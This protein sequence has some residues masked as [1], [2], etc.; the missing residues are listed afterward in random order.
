M[1]TPKADQIN[2]DGIPPELI[3]LRQWVCWRYERRGGK[4]T[5]V[6]YRP[7][8]RK[9]ADSTNP[10]T[11]GDYSDA[12]AGLPQFSGIGFVFS[13]SDPY[14]GID[15]DKVRDP[16][17]DALD[18][19]ASDVLAMIGSYAELSPSG[20]GIHV[21]AKARLT[22]TRRRKG[23]VEMYD[24]GRYFAMTGRVLAG[25]ETINARQAEV[26]AL[27]HKVFGEMGHKPASPTSPP[28]ARST[29]LDDSE[30][31]DHAKRARNGADFARLWAGDT[32]GYNSPSEADSALCFH[33]AW[34]TSGDAARIDRLYRASAL[35]RDK[36]DR[37]DYRERTIT[38]AIETVGAGYTGKPDKSHPAGPSAAIT[39]ATPVDSP[40]DDPP[41]IVLD[42]NSEATF[43]SS[44]IREIDQS[45]GRLVS[46]DG[47]LYRY[48][49]D[50]GVWEPLDAIAMRGRIQSLLN[51]AFVPRANGTY[52]PLAMNFSRA[53][54]TYNSMLAHVDIYKP[55]YFDNVEP[56][57]A[58]SNGFVRVDSDGIHLAPHS[59][60][61]RARQRLLSDYR[62]DAESQSWLEMLTGLFDGD[63]DSEDKRK[64]LQEFAGACMCGLA[65]T[66]DKCAVFVGGGGNGKSTA[67]QA[68]E[69]N[70]FLPGT[71]AHVS[72][73]K[74]REAY[75]VSS[76]C[77]KLVNIVS[78]L[79]SERLTDNDIF[80]S[81]ITG[82]VVMARDPYKSPYEFRP[83][84]GHIFA[85]NDLPST[86]DLTDGFWQR[87]VFLTFNRNFRTNPA[88]WESRDSILARIRADAP[89]VALW[90]LH[91]AVRLL[92]HGYTTPKSSGDVQED[93]HQTSCSVREWMAAIKPS[94]NGGQVSSADLYRAYRQ[95]ALDNGRQPV[96]S[97]EMGRRLA[98]YGLENHRSN[99]HRFWAVDWVSDPSPGDRS[100]R[101]F[102]GY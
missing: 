22:G 71:V 87:F 84:A 18:P 9:K 62:P 10:A 15:L 31:I 79:P 92:R 16:A 61:N 74:W 98:R 20:S 88:A 60:G 41:R 45:G 77:G 93:W 24:C 90:A 29:G 72:P 65:T 57:I 64:F 11:W 102:E 70:I 39:T 67:Q 52:S 36:W 69:Q 47:R 50:S 6:P 35:M 96:S 25:H 73:Q 99:A 7:G 81:V 19:I 32:S 95:W 5:K 2:P 101:L 63:S 75:S 40:L 51:G 76:L 38:H 27:H 37:D 46:T 91:G 17:T 78:E 80:K 68:L 33:L 82:D 44:M 43:A 1:N 28:I 83:K 42:Q 48:D 89:G 85:C 26:E 14:C 34:W 53:V 100:N 55:G 54:G 56:G 8:S 58:F 49:S 66:Y 94:A 23:R 4:W 97:I 13:A 21:I 3:A 30:L 86:N 12:L 59:E